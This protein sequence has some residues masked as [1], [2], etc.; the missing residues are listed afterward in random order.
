MRT[1]PDL[2]HRPSDVPALQLLFLSEGYSDQTEFLQ[3]SS[4][5][6]QAFLRIAPFRQH[7]HRIAAWAHFLS[8]AEMVSAT[9]R[10]TGLRL[11]VDVG[12]LLTTQKPQ[13]IIDVLLGLQVSI[14]NLGDPL[15]FIDASEVWLGRLVDEEA[16]VCV[17][18]KNSAPSSTTVFQWPTT[19]VEPSAETQ[20]LR[21]LLPCIFLSSC[22]LTSGSVPQYS[23]PHEA[24][25]LVLAKQC[26]RILGLA[27]ERELAGPAFKVYTI[28]DPAN[29]SSILEP[30]SPNVT[31]YASLA[32]DAGQLDL[33][34]LKW[35]AFLAPRQM[36]GISEQAYPAPP[37]GASDAQVRQLFDQTARI[38]DT[39]VL[40]L[41]HRGL[42]DQS[43]DAP[44]VERYATGPRKPLS[45]SGAVNLFEGAAG[46]RQ[47][48]FRPTGEC[49]MRFDGYDD[50]TGGVTRRVAVDLCPICAEHA[51]RR[52]AGA[53]A[54]T[55]DGVKIKTAASTCRAKRESRIAQALIKYIDLATP[56]HGEMRR[57][58]GSTM[59]C[60]EATARRFED[61]FRGMLKW[62]LTKTVGTADWLP[63][64]L[65]LPVL[66]GNRTSSDHARRAWSIWNTK[67]EPKYRSGRKD[68]YALPNWRSVSWAGLG[69]PGALAY[70]GFG[71]IVNRRTRKS[72]VREGRTV[73]YSDVTSL[74]V[75]D[76]DNLQPGSLLQLWKTHHMFEEF[77]IYAELSRLRIAAG[78]EPNP[79]PLG[80]GHS[81]YFVG[82]I[83][84]AAHVADQWDTARLLSDWN[85]YPFRIAAQWFDATGHTLL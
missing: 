55:L 68:P 66:Y 27:D 64:E 54:F 26:G 9:E 8:S 3:H 15:E 13:R 14:P 34:R 19:L 58:D 38:A 5:I 12:G 29:G 43:Q 84:G 2:I 30:Q 74:A 69:A 32:D 11:Y 53:A 77:V 63:T 21:D 81:L 28:T 70:L 25:G 61:F 1:R 49:L 20:E 46:F 39:S 73:R 51:R 24:V 33:D 45:L 41:R 47:G 44:N 60:V 35:R 56:S 7:S 62:P 48:L 78:L 75:S 79:A 59:A 85:E 76:F 42:N 31:A 10:N 52:L 40:M 37:S 22:W 67:L 83:D 17:L 6:M 50:T 4:R 72:T 23:N 80:E 16:V 71:C 57:S 18:A 36:T 82:M 65:E